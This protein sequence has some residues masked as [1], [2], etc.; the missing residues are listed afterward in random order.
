MGQHQQL[1]WFSGLK[2][3]SFHRR[4]R[5]PTYRM[6]PFRLSTKLRR[7]IALNQLPLG[8]LYSLRISIAGWG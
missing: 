6:L 4:V 1:Q 7:Q 2:Q 5:S 8:L 3:I